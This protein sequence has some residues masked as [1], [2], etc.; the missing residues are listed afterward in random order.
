MSS[1]IPRWSPEVASQEG[2]EA[3]LYSDATSVKGKGTDSGHLILPT[4]AP[5]AGPGHLLKAPP[6]KASA[7]LLVA[8]GTDPAGV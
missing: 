6:L 3:K 2:W 5:S 1:L 8:D 7:L 4:R